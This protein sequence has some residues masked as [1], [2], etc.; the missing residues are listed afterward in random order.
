MATWVKTVEEAKE[1]ASLLLDL[2]RA[3]PVCVIS[4]PNDDP[5]PVFDVEGIEGD[6]SSVC[7][8]F[9]IVGGAATRELQ[10]LLP[11]EMHVFGG[12]AR[13][14]P[15]SFGRTKG[16]TAGKLRYVYPPG[17]LKQSS[18]RLAADIWAAAMDAGL[19]DQATENAVDVVGTVKQF[20]GDDTAVLQLESGQLVSLRQETTFPGVPLTW[21]FNLGQQVTGKF[22]SSTRIFTVKQQTLTAADAVAHFGYDTVTLGL[23]QAADRKKASIAIHPNLVFDVTK[24]EITGNPLDVINEYLRVGEVWPVRIYRDPQGRTR[25]KMNDIDDDEPIAE[26]LRLVDS[27][28]PW[29]DQARYANF[30]GEDVEVGEIALSEPLV[31]DESAYLPPTSEEPGLAASVV[32]SEPTAPATGP[33]SL[34]NLTASTEAK[35]KAT[36]LHE[37]AVTHY[38]GLIRIANRENERLNN[39]LNQLSG[40]YRELNITTRRLRE[41]ASTYKQL[42]AE[43]RKSRSGEA[44][45]AGG[46]YARRDRFDSLEDWFNE[47]LRRTWFRL[48]T[49]ADRTRYPLVASEWSFGPEFLND[50]NP[51]DLD[52]TELR[53]LLRVSLHLVTGRNGL[54]HMTE[55]HELRVNNKPLMRGQDVG[56]RMHIEN[57]QP[58]AK[59]LHYFKLGKGGFEFSRVGNHDEYLD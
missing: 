25:L 21:V 40:S 31:L 59:R 49:P 22:D 35:D 30:G 37:Q 17:T 24:E 47:E 4:T 34:V 15:I 45:L 57:G 44:K 10:D 36:R 56:L 55:W 6:V 38:L 18:Q 48:Y 16:E 11:A 29:L 7:E 54:E 51:R 50:V 27:G 33:A 42:V 8:V 58:Q 19:L 12:A 9:V 13:T 1:L 5:A 41:E 20:Y 53:K 46:A 23:V 14:Y 43:S 26:A 52:E 2:R 32:A 39:E 3:K 28:E